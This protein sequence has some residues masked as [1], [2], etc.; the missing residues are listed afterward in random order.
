MRLQQYLAQAGVASRRAAERLITDGKV[1]VNG[2]AVA[3]LG[4][5]GNPQSDRV[6]VEGRRGRPEAPLYR[7]IPKARPGPATPGGQG[8]GRPAPGPDP[9]APELGPHEGAPRAQ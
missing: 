6:E 3:A 8:G 9:P 5:Q 7:G 4:T 1:R 2:V